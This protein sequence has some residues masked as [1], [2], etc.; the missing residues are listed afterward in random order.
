MLLKGKP[1][2]FYCLETFLN[3]DEISQVVLAVPADWKS[4][5]EKDILEN[6]GWPAEMLNKLTI[7][8]GGSERWQSVRNGVN[9]L[10]GQAEYVLVH[11]VARPFVSK[12]IIANVCKTLVEKGSCLVAKPDVDTIKVAEDGKVEKTIDRKKVWLAQTPQAASVSLL[13]SLYGRI[14]RE[15]LDFTPTDEASILEFFGENVYIVQGNAMNDKLTTPE[16][17]EIFSARLATK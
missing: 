17:F 16:D 9:A 12:E 14:D 4:H 2:Y 8:V 6:S 15:P 5:F 7:V 13:K 3:M 11:D 1:V 10:S